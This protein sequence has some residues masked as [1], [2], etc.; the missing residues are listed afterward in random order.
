MTIRYDW[1]RRREMAECI[2][3]SVA[4]CCTFDKKL[5]SLLWWFWFLVFCFHGRLQLL[6]D[7]ECDLGVGWVVVEI[8]FLLFCFLFHRRMWST[9]VLISYRYS[10]TH[11]IMAVCVAI[12]QLFQSA[13]QKYEIIRRWKWFF[14]VCV[15][16][17]FEAQCEA[18]LLAAAAGATCLLEWHVAQAAKWAKYL[19]IMFLIDDVCVDVCSSI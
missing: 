5:S 12:C 19:F 8:D 6:I 18:R 11:P 16:K 1:W 13:L 10:F 4:V 2:F 14:C 9:T 17:Y 15:K 3:C 7:F